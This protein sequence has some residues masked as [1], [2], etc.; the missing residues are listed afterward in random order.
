MGFIPPN[1][2][3]GGNYYIRPAMPGPLPMQPSGPCPPVYMN[4]AALLLG[5][6][7]LAPLIHQK[8]GMTPQETSQF[9]KKLLQL[10]KE[11]QELVVT[12]VEAQAQA[13]ETKATV[14]QAAALLQENPDIAL[15]SLQKLLA[16]QAKHGQDK[17]MGLL[18]SA[19]TAHTGSSKEIGE[20]LSTVTQLASQAA[21][22]P[23]KALATTMLLYL[24]YYPLQMGQKL[25]PWYEGGDEEESGGGGGGEMFVF[26]LETVHLGRFKASF[27]QLAPNQTAVQLEHDAI[28]APY[29]EALEAE[30]QE[31]LAPLGLPAPVFEYKQR[32]AA[33]GSHVGAGSVYSSTEEKSMQ[34]AMQPM[35]TVSSWLTQTAYAVVRAIFELDGRQGLMAHRASQA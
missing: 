33:P 11:F 19:R 8:A 9:L 17:L 24:P 16:T 26:M 10:P 13:P 23:Q 29:L 32:A 35:G 15:E 34:V 12:L 30:T 28:A 22:S 1:N 21:E 5:E 4:P 7:L 14:Q 20:M 25:E 18:Q 6:L 27:S 31:Q 2:N 3:F